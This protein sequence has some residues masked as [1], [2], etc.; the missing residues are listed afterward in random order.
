VVV[1]CSDLATMGR[2]PCCS[3]CG[4]E[5]VR[6]CCTSGLTTKVSDLRCLRLDIEFGMAPPQSLHAIFD[7][8]L[9]ALPALWN[10]GALLLLVFFIYAY[11]GTLLL[12]NISNR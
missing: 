3:R 5:V 6:S 12:G 7:T 8:L 2:R 4:A 9:L 10:V 1:C 11:I